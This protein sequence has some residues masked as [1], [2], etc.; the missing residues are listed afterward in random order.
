MA[1]EKL[2]TEIIEKHPGDPYWIFCRT[3]RQLIALKQ[4]RRLWELH[5]LQKI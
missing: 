5:R 3:E 2:R 1:V 4:I